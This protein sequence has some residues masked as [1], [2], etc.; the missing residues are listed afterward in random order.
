[1]SKEADD[2][3]RTP[4]KRLSLSPEEHVLLH[5]LLNIEK[6]RII[7]D[8]R[9][10]DVQEKALEVAD[11]HNRRIFEF[12]SKT[13]DDNVAL[14]RE[15]QRRLSGVVWTLL[16]LAGFTVFAVLGF[17][18]LGNETQRAAAAE[19]GSPA[20]IGIAGYGVIKVLVTAVKGLIGR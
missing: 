12:E 1:M 7:R 14:E 11:A 20:L 6:Q 13:R 9:R 3:S 2:E 10:A 5:N 16:G 15:K 19:I 18:F 8:N 4:E 17:F